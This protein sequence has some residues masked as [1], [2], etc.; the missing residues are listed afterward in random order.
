LDIELTYPV[1]DIV[2][3]LR[4][5]SFKWKADDIQDFGLIAE[6]V[7]VFMK[8]LVCYNSDGTPETIAYHK[9][10]V[11]LLKYCK[12]MNSEMQSLKQRIQDL[13]QK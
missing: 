13:E 3:S 1:N 8:D 2:N 11:L 6:E 5:V 9:L 10:P 4:P 12:T 7:D